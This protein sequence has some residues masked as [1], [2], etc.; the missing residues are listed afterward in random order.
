MKATLL[1]RVYTADKITRTRVQGFRVVQGVVQVGVNLGEVTGSGGGGSYR[2]LL[3]C[4]EM[5]R[6]RDVVVHAMV[7]AS[8]AHM[9]VYYFTCCA[10]KYIIIHNIMSCSRVHLSLYRYTITTMI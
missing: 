4:H 1:R 5:S 6:E 2:A 3:S 7:H 8:T 10:I 9:M